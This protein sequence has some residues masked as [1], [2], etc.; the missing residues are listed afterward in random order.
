MDVYEKKV[1]AGFFSES[2]FLEKK[3]ERECTKKR[4][5]GENVWHG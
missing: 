4:T 3:G 1:G 2:L 5:M